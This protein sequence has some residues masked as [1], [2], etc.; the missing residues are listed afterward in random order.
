MFISWARRSSAAL[1]RPVIHPV[2]RPAVCAKVSPWP[3]CA[4]KVLIS[5]AVPSVCESRVTLPS[6]MVPSTSMR[7]SLI[8]AARFLSEGE[9]LAKPAK[10]ASRKMRNFKV[11]AR[12]VITSKLLFH[13]TTWQIPAPQATA[14]PTLRRVPIRKYSANRS[15]DSGKLA[16]DFP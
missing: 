1:S 6:V 8:C 14:S 9:I 12:S 4:S 11:K 3:S 2:R 16:I 15:F 7:S 5:R 10:K 13:T